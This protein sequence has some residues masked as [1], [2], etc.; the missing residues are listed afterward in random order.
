M[1]QRL[2]IVSLGVDDLAAATAF[3]EKLGWRPSAANS[4]DQITFFQLGGMILGL[5][6]RQALAEDAPPIWPDRS[7]NRSIDCHVGDAAETETAFDQAAHV[8]RL[9]SQV[10]RITGARLADRS[11]RREYFDQEEAARHSER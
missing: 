1:E 9:E 5:Y 11:L 4:N 2:S 6:G 7:D 8:V 3:Y 10:N